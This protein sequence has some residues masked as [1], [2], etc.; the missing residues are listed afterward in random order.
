MAKRA[1]DPVNRRSASRSPDHAVWHSY[2]GTDHVPT[3]SA[4]QHVGTA[5]RETFHAFA[6]AVADN[7][8]PLELTLNMWFVLRS[9]WEIDGRTQVDLA[10]KLEVTPAAMVGIVNGLEAAGWVE[11]RRSETDGRAFRVFLTPMGHKVRTKASGQALQVDA[12]ALRGFS[13][14]EVG[15]LL[16]LMR[17]LRTNLSD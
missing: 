16:D 10:S 9:L 1:K 5:L 13:V 2:L 7:L 15:T 8:R 12:K 3:F 14:A 6:H 4:D 11:R 17:R